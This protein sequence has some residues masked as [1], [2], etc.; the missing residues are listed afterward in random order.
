MEVLYFFH[1]S[2]LFGNFCKK[3]KCQRFSVTPHFG[4]MVCFS[5]PPIGLGLFER[6]LTYICALLTRKQESFTSYQPF[7]N[8]TTLSKTYTGNKMYY[9]TR[10]INILLSHSF[11]WSVIGVKNTSFFVDR[12]SSWRMEIICKPPDSSS[13]SRFLLTMLWTTQLVWRL[14]CRSERKVVIFIR[15]QAGKTEPLKLNVP[16]VMAMWFHRVHKNIRPDVLG[17]TYPPPSIPLSQMFALKRIWI[18]NGWPQ[19]TKHL[20]CI[21]ESL[22]SWL[23]RRCRGL[24]AGLHHPMG[25][26]PSP[27]VLASYGFVVHKHLQTRRQY[28]LRFDYIALP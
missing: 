1:G 10:F 27:A 13:L 18:F 21:V 5:S 25:T 3:T 23:R 19:C 9:N 12:V 15:R 20:C 8:A 28:T 11:I 6:N 4:W 16:V 17:L 24:L 26:S 7:S 22:Q 2:C 14:W